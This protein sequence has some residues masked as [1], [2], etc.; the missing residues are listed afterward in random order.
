[1]R[2]RPREVVFTTFEDEREVDEVRR[3][4]GMV[5]A[6]HPNCQLI[7]QMTDWMGLPGDVYSQV[8][9]RAP[10]VDQ[11]IDHTVGA[12]ADVV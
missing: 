5:R 8:G 6:F 12:K 4:L 9:V 7:E 11:L 10:L 1:M 2:C 3:R